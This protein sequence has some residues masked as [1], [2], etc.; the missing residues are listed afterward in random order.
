MGGWVD[1][2]V[3]TYIQTDI[4]TYDRYLYLN[5]IPLS[6]RCGGTFLNFCITRRHVAF[7]SNLLYLAKETLVKV[8]L[9]FRHNVIKAWGLGWR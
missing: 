5:N 4:H 8:T 7:R 2:Y 1:R 9:L 3:R 6:L